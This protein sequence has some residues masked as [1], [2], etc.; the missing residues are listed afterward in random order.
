MPTVA[1]LVSSVE[2]AGQTGEGVQQ[3]P[4]LPASQDQDIGEQ[5]QELL[6]NLDQLSDREVDTLLIDILGVKDS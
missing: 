3:P 5:S 2:A 4:I 1:G 6:A